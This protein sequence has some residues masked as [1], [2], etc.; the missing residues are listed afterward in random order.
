M[1]GA[2]PGPGLG[3]FVGALSAGRLCSLVG[4]LSALPP[5]S[6][7]SSQGPVAPERPRAPPA[8][9]SRLG[10]PRAARRASQV[11]GSESAPGRAHRAGRGALNVA[12]VA[13]G[14]SGAVPPYTAR[15][16]PCRSIRG[17][18]RPG[19]GRRSASECGLQP[20]SV[21]GPSRCR[22]RR[23]SSRVAGGRGDA[24]RGATP[25]RLTP[26]VLRPG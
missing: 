24:N 20:P 18:G 21:S 13:M 9:R 23:P 22:R 4:E 3:S 19:P 11:S 17:Y 1:R 10:G 25:A 14:R 16:S 12:L 15:P 26:R 8:E 7:G 5:S 2:F 6:A